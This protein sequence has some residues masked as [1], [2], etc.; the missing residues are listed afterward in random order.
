MLLRLDR[1]LLAG[2]MTMCCTPRVVLRYPLFIFPFFLFSHFLSFTFP[3]HTS[4]FP[5]SPL[6]YYFLTSPLFSLLPRCPLPRRTTSYP[7]Q[8]TRYQ[9]SGRPRRAKFPQPYFLFHLQILRFRAQVQD[10]YCPSLRIHA[11]RMQ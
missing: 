8:K 11:P 2:F 7:F 10:N 6:P 9:S 1:T 5:F 4:L 3:P